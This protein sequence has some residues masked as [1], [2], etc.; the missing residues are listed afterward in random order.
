MNI[1]KRAI[2]H[3]TACQQ[4]SNAN[5]GLAL[6]SVF[7]THT[8]NKPNGVERLVD[9][10]QRGCLMPDSPPTFKSLASKIA[11]LPFPEAKP[12]QREIVKS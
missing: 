9:G 11:I 6:C 2:L 5:K 7:L 12:I 3:V 8:S 4:A 1:V 10:V